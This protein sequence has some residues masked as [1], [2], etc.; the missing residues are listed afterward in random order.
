MFVSSRKQK[1]KCNFLFNDFCNVVKEIIAS[2]R[3]LSL[4]GLDQLSCSSSYLTTTTILSLVVA[5]LNFRELHICLILLTSMVYYNLRGNKALIQKDKQSI[6][7]QKEAA[8]NHY[9]I[10]LLF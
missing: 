6:N 5:D 8:M 3:T 4:V 7:I 10:N 2:K 1:V 9:E